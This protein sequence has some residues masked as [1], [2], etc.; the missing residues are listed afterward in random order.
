[1]YFEN[2]NKVYSFK[3]DLIYY[4][5]FNYRVSGFYNIKISS[6]LSISLKEA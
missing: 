5:L 4:Y 1:M 3:V 2:I 6:E